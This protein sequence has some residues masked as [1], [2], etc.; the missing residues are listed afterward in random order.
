MIL[1]AGRPERVLRV[2]YNIPFLL[3]L[4]S[5]F[6]SFLS[7]GAVSFFFVYHYLRS[8]RP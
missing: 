4:S 6:P 8:L 5:I 3:S 7:Q 2:R 1:G